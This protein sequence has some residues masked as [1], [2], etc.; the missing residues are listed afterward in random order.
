MTI[1]SIVIPRRQPIHSIHCV[2]GRG[3]TVAVDTESVRGKNWLLGCCIH[4]DVRCVYWA[5]HFQMKVSKKL[6][7]A[8]KL[9][10]HKWK[11]M[12][13]VQKICIFA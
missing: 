10:W 13:Y 12:D 2:A 3:C 1:R 6:H 9:S 8:E 11:G 5:V 7:R 4:V